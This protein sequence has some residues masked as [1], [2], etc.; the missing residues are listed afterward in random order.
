VRLSFG[1][2]LFSRI[3]WLLSRISMRQYEK[4]WCRLFPASTLYF[5]LQARPLE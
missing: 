3:G 5:R 1:S 2:G 4:Y